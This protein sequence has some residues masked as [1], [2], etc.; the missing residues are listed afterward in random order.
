MKV[1]EIFFSIQGESSYAGFP[2]GFVRLAG[3]NLR[4][5][6]CDTTYA[7]EQGEEMTIGNVAEA[8][9]RFPAN[10]VE[11]TGGEPLLQPETGLL[12]AT[13]ADSGRTVLIETNGALSIEGVDARATVIMDIKCPGSGMSERMLWDNV[14]LLKPRDE[15]KFV[16][17]DRADYE[18][19]L[20][21]IKRRR[22]DEKHVV[23][24]APA[25]G[26]LKP[27]SLAAWMLEDK[28]NVR[29]QLQLHKY[30]WP[31]VQRGV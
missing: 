10:L 23:H 2:C 7:Y 15:I 11:I 3:C 29:L 9:T 12:A 1:N 24:L 22:L 17:T 14:A 25:F 30:I 27:S 8:L 4:C 19:A 5:S 18:W 16:L 28:M 6:Y 31:R 20:G 26:I 13:L 21:I